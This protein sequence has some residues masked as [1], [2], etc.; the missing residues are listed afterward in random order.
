MYGI[1]VAGMARSYRFLRLHEPG[2]SVCTSRTLAL[3]RGRVLALCRSWPCLRNKLCSQE[4]LQDI[5]PFPPANPTTHASHPNCRL[6][7]HARLVLKPRISH[8]GR[9]FMPDKLAKP[10][11]Y[12]T[13]WVVH[14]WATIT[15]AYLHCRS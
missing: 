10:P 11:T 6:G 1:A 7:I 2:V 14:L 15:T 8:V 12:T 4:F 5:T 13:P 3:C 9:A